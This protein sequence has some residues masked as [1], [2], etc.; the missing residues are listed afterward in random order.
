MTLIQNAL[1]VDG[2]GKPARRADLLIDGGVIQAV[3]A[4]I[5]A[6]DGATVYDVSG[7][8][9]APGFI[10]A[11]T[12]DDVVVL[13]GE[14]EAKLSQGATTV[15]VGNCGFS[16]A[17]WVPSSERSEPPSPLGLLGEADRFA[18]PEFPAYF[19]A[20]AC[21]DAEMGGRSRDNTVVL[22]GHS[23]LRAARVAD[24]GA[25]ARQEELA[26]ME[27]DLE[28][29]LDAGCRGLSAGLAYPSALASSRAEVMALARIAFKRGKVFAVHLRNEYEGVWD[30]LDE[31][32]SIGR[33][34]LGG[35]VEPG[36][37][38]V[39][40]HQKCAGPANR[41]RAEELLER[42]E[43]AARD[44]PLAFDAYPYEAGSTMLEADSARASR[45]VIITWSRPHPECA[46]MELAEATE[47]LGLSQEDALEALKP[48]G[49]AYFHMDEADVEA[50]LSHP[51]CMVGSD[52]LP[53]DTLPHP[54]LYGTFPRYLRRMVRQA[55][56]LC[57]EEAVRKITSL[58]ASVF[59]LQHKGVIRP[60][61]DA[62]I[63]VFR[64][65]VLTDR[66]SW[67]EPRLT[68]LG[69]ELVLRGGK[70]VFPRIK[71]NKT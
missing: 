70:P 37:R 71:G 51:L 38:L 7:A 49:G 61:A 67:K 31:V 30:A 2:S 27:R 63:V 20:L 5:R 43:R 14:N 32:F 11:H 10:D 26:S 28:V 18:F 47:S 54:R 46:G 22:C 16:L 29:A 66:A 33:E 62:D 24:L 19:D 60:G 50:I 69:I 6:P 48:G 3:E 9:V 64:S 40:S 8:V 56:S 35:S 21:A 39:L 1:V 41:G 42:I 55:K 59:S 57:L 34:A 68:S 58:P 13:E 17:P 12:H 4:R 23:S 25:P 45:R 44:I 53:A 65:D 36:A 52:G 15:V